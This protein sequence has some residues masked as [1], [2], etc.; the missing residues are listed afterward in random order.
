MVPVWR[1]ARPPKSGLVVNRVCSCSMYAL[2]KN[3]EERAACRLPESPLLSFCTDYHRKP[4]G[5]QT[6][7]QVRILICRHPRPI[8]ISTTRSGADLPIIYGRAFRSS[9]GAMRPSEK[10]QLVFPVADSRSTEGSRFHTTG[11]L[12]RS[13]RHNECRPL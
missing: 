3:Q 11:G 6:V 10:A 7:Q 13:Q 4:Y 2:L 1:I 9:I 12:T 5:Q 8:H